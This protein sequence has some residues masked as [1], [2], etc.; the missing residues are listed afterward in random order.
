MIAFPSDDLDAIVFVV[1]ANDR[2]R[3]PEAKR[4]LDSL[5]CSEETQNIPLLILGNKNDL[6]TAGS[7]EEVEYALGLIGITSLGEVKKRKLNDFNN[8]RRQP[9][10]LFMCSA[11]QGTG[12]M[13]GFK[14]LLQQVG[15]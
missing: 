11:M 15:E 13:D 4:D 5:F 1:D 9:I 3:F 8:A 14:W 7:K 10:E 2:G 6:P 12:Y